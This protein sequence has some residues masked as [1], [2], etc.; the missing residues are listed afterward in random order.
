MPIGKWSISEKK[1]KYQSH[2]SLKK[3]KKKKKLKGLQM[4]LVL[5][6][7]KDFSE[8]KYW[9]MQPAGLNAYNTTF[10]DWILLIF[11]NNVKYSV[12]H[13]MARLQ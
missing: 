12:H 10:S 11:Y 7:A 6:W 5:F 2:L 13:S 4:N 1:K 3:K 8:E 9:F